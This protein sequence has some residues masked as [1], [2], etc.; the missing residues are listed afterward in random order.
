MKLCQSLRAAMVKTSQSYGF[1]V[2][3]EPFTNVHIRRAF[4]FAIDRQSLVDNVLQ[5]G[6][7]AA[8]FFSN[9]TLAAKPFEAETPKR[10]QLFSCL[11]TSFCKNAR[12][13]RR[14]HQP[15]THYELDPY[16]KTEPDVVWTHSIKCDLN[17]KLNII[18]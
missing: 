7:T 10:K 5:G 16:L 13:F 3:V 14:C 9:P 17:K 1:S 18:S 2:G 15:T 6:Q 12:R 8:G 4:S 11:R